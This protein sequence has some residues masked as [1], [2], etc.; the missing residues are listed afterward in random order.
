MSFSTFRKLDYVLFYLIISILFII[1]LME[2]SLA[3]VIGILIGS[4]IPALILGTIT[5]F[6]FRKK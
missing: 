3:P 5:N 2:L 1:Q 6:I 4:I